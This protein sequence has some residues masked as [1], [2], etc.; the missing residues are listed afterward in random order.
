MSNAI[1]TLL[2]AEYGKLQRMMVRLGEEC[3][4][5][6]RGSLAIKQ[7]GR[8]NYVYLVKREDGKV[9]TTY[10]GKE[11]S[12]QVKGIEAKIIERRRYE[13]ELVLAE[14]QLRKVKKIMKA[15]GVFF[16]EP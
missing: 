4:Q 14:I 2:T 16:V 7:R 9:V 10:I 15:S 5:R 1:D 8:N 3:K 6:P 11:G 13:H 12:W